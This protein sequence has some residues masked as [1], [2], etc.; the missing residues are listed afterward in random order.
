[1]IFSKARAQLLLCARPKIILLN[2]LAYAHR[3]HGLEEELNDWTGEHL[4]PASSIILSARLPSEIRQVA[5]HG[6]LPRGRQTN[7]IRNLELY[8]LGV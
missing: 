5:V 1:V 8:L 3:R 7:L 2:E 4:L 6:S